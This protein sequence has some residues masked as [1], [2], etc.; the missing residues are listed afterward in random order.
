M[1]P[2]V[3]L[4]V[5]GV[6]FAARRGVRYAALIQQQRVA[7]LKQ[8]GPRGEGGQRGGGGEGG[9]PLGGGFQSVR[10]WADSKLGHFGS[11]WKSFS[12]DLRGFESPMTKAEAYQIL[13]LT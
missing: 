12:R 6:A 7:A 9:F 13:R 3:C 5:G 2:L 11:R 8:Q 1:W 4:L 10:D